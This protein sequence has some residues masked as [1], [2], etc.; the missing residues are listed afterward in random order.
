MANTD[1]LADRRRHWETVYRAKDATSVS[2]Y[3]ETLSVSLKMIEA[4]GL[5]HGA[6]IIDVGGGASTLVDRL[7][8]DGY[9]RWSKHGSGWER[10]PTGSTGW[11]RT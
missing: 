10:T 11:L 4:T 3:Q 5:G 1:R 7:I 2:W 8:A 9:E 6:R